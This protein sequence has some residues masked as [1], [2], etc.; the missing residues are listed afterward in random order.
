LI[1]GVEPAKKATPGGID[2][3]ATARFICD[4]EGFESQKYRDPSGHGW[5]IGC[6]HAARGRETITRAESEAIVAQEVE[7]LAPTIFGAY[8]AISQQKF[9]GIVSILYNT[10]VRRDIVAN[11][12]V[13]EMIASGDA[14]NTRWFFD[15][16]IRAVE[17]AAGVSLGGLR[18]RRAKEFE[19]IF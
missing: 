3:I 15:R 5:V 11:K 16:Q 19:M 10:P 7:R 17:N 1:A 8:G 14:E 6:G 18:K 13:V 4:M 2:Y 9:T 12:N